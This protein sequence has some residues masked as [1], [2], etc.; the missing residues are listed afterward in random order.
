[1][2]AATSTLE[3]RG[4]SGDTE[5]V[6]LDHSVSAD[7]L[8]WTLRR[9]KADGTLVQTIAGTVSHTAVITNLNTPDSP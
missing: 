9:T 6:I 4:K 2:D 8:E 3:W 5:F 7:R 1:M